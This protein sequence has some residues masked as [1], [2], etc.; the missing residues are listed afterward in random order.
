MQFSESSASRFKKISVESST[1]ENPYEVRTN[2]NGFIRWMTSEIFKM[3]GLSKQVINDF[4][5]D[6]KERLEARM[7]KE[8]AVKAKREAA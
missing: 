3:K 2:L 6:A 8:A 4:I 5:R 7:T 1:S